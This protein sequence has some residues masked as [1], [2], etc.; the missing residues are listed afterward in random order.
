[1][2]YET[3]LDCGSVDS[4]DSFLAIAV[5]PISAEVMPGSAHSEVSCTAC[6]GNASF[7]EINVSSM[8]ICEKCHTKEVSDTANSK[9][10]GL[11]ATRPDTLPNTCLVCHNPHQGV[12]K[13]G[14]WEDQSV[15]E[16][17]KHAFK[18][19]KMLTETYPEHTWRTFS[20]MNEF[21]LDCHGKGSHGAN[22]SEP[23]KV[24]GE[25]GAWFQQGW[26]D[27]VVYDLDRVVPEVEGLGD[28]RGALPMDDPDFI[29][30]DV[31][32]LGTS[33]YYGAGNAP[34]GSDNYTE[35]IR[36]CSKACHDGGDIVI[37][38]KAVKTVPASGYE[39]S[40]CHAVTN[41]TVSKIETGNHASYLTQDCTVCHKPHTF[42]MV[43]SAITA[44]P[45][46]ATPRPATP[47]F[48]VLFAAGG[49]GIATVI[50]MKR[51]R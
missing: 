48:G 39:C 17:N 40:D 35:G 44:T 24:T 4:V 14:E 19:K 28:E 36:N 5:V 15:A 23:S 2:Q 21:C 22:V 30:W 16:Y 31:W 38:G 7:T 8:E 29:S 51:R 41:D 37:A 47:G 13:D 42:M 10:T 50:C 3:S 9:H 43:A 25:E 46:A 12:Y 49:I 1:M 32:K 33:T 27:G 11:G 34:Y 26:S 6:H 20:S 45:T 18:G